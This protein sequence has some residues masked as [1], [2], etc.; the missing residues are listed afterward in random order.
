MWLKNS[1]R[2][3]LCRVLDVSS[4]PRLAF[5]PPDEGGVGPLGA[6]GRPPRNR[7]LNGPG[8]GIDY[9]GLAFGFGRARGGWNLRGGSRSLRSLWTRRRLGRIGLHD[10]DAPFEIRAV[11]DHDA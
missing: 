1:S 2:P 9:F 7:F 11:F 10:I 6:A 3:R 5:R 8:N 4:P